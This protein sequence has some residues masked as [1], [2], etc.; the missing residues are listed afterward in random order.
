MTKKTLFGIL[1][2]LGVIL[3]LLIFS[4]PKD[5][6]YELGDGML[7]GPNILEPYYR[8]FVINHNQVVF[9]IHIPLKKL[10]VQARSD[11]KD[12]IA[13]SCQM[14]SELPREIYGYPRYST[15][16]ATVLIHKDRVVEW[17]EWIRRKER[18]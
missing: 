8:A 5:K 18:L 7:L 3:I 17:S 4:G 10:R 12:L 14:N 6:V 15:E 16:Q 9:G 1:G 13:I 11:N 2:L